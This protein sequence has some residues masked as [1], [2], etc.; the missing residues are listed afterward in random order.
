MKQA[1]TILAI[2]FATIITKAQSK[3]KFGGGVNYYIPSSTQ[4]NNT[5][6]FLFLESAQSVGLELS[7]APNTKS[8][9][10][11]KL[12]ANYI[13]GT[14][15]KNAIA[16]Y[17]KEN[18]IV[19]TGYQFTKTNP[20]GFSIMASPQFM[21]FPKSQNKK[22][23]LIWLDFKVG[24]LFSNQQSL[25]FFNGQTIPSKEVKKQCGEFCVQSN[26]GG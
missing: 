5:S 22:L 10:R 4:K 25:Q 17:A 6:P 18:N 1:I 13:T 9:T 12:A 20:S 7:F 16:A 14:N 21:L 2:L 11:I 15:D 8:S 26:I 23:P 24:A 19:N 3:V